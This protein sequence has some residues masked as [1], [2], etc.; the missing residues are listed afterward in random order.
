MR[1]AARSAWW[2]KHTEEVCV[3]QAVYAAAEY[4]SRMQAPIE[5]HCGGILLKRF[6]EIG[7]SQF[8][9]VQVAVSSI[10]QLCPATIVSSKIV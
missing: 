9:I 10:Q 2:C 8:W 4:Y 7:G 1:S 3:K 5:E 6:A